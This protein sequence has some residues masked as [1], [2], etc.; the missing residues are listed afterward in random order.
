M[1][2]EVTVT[3]NRAA[4]LFVDYFEVVHLMTARIDVEQNTVDI[5]SEDILVDYAPSYSIA[6]IQDSYLAIGY[7]LNEG[8]TTFGVQ[9]I[10]GKETLLPSGNVSISLT[11]TSTISLKSQPIIMK[12]G[13]WNN[14]LENNM[15]SIL[16]LIT[17]NED[18]LLIYHLHCMPDFKSIRVGT[19]MYNRNSRVSS[20]NMKGIHHFS[21]LMLIHNKFMVY[22]SSIINN[23]FTALQIGYLTPSME[24]IADGPQFTVSRDI[25]DTVWNNNLYCD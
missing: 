10:L 4:F 21:I 18:D 19:Q 22:Y 20:N 25:R 15:N 16:A 7:G 17:E 13:S 24:L 12:I 5:T 1:H 6:Y 11:P 8:N 14:H 23:G 3:K 9:I 2:P